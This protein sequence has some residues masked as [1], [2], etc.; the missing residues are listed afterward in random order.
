MDAVPK[1]KASEFTQIQANRTTT[2]STSHATPTTNSTPSA[3]GSSDHQNL[4]AIQQNNLHQPAE[5][6]LT[7]PDQSTHEIHRD[8]HHHEGYGFTLN[9]IDWNLRKVV[10]PLGI[11]SSFMWGI[12]NILEHGIHAGHPS[13]FKVLVW[14]GQRAP[15]FNLFYGSF[16]AIGAFAQGYIMRGAAFTI[17]TGF[18]AVLARVMLRD[19]RLSL[20][21]S[22]QLGKQLTPELEKLA[23]DGLKMR[24]W[25]TLYNAVAPIGM[26][27]GLF[28]ITKVAQS[29]P[30]V[31]LEHPDGH[32]FREFFFA[33]NPDHRLPAVLRR[34]FHRE[35]GSFVEVAQ[36]SVQNAKDGVKAFNEGFWN[37]VSPSPDKAHLSVGKRFMDPIVSGNTVPLFYTHA[38]MGRVLA[39]TIAVFIFFRVSRAA[40][41]KESVYT[42]I[43][44]TGPSGEVGNGV[45]SSGRGKWTDRALNTAL[46]WGQ[47]AGAPAGLLTQ[48]H[49]WP[50]PLS[51]V[52]RSS[53]LCYGA[54][55]ICSILNLAKIKNFGP[56]IKGG[57]VLGFD[58]RAWTKI[59]AFIQGTSYFVN[60]FFK[61]RKLEQEE[62][63]HEIHHIHPH[64]HV[65]DPTNQP[66]I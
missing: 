63:Q 44:G 31:K 10:P 51:A 25:T 35:W 12:S 57:K 50:L 42:K 9:P 2:N 46:L 59:G 4:Q 66:S 54:S 49:D 29:H 38:C 15:Y 19:N 18:S 62:H 27:T 43:L 56:L 47:L 23:K 60:L 6:N 65:H 14:I 24:V 22:K 41:L 36:N 34:N 45:T 48:F 21:L 53:G 5:I 52:Y 8:N 37:V 61:N 1:L 55:A 39:S 40:L 13:R 30:G 11:A 33:E 17:F 16:N 26:L 3:K 28:S 20:M 7:I 64:N 58:E 32:T